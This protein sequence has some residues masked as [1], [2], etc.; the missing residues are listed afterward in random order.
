MKQPIGS[1]WESGTSFFKTFCAAPLAQFYEKHKSRINHILELLTALFMTMQAI[2]ILKSNH[3]ALGG[4]EVNHK[5]T[6][7]LLAL[8]TPPAPPAPP[9]PYM[10]RP[11]GRSLLAFFG[12]TERYDARLGRVRASC[13][14]I[15]RAIRPFRKSTVHSTE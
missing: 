5:L 12:R 13:M 11:G 1:G 3:K 14:P 2:I 10:R 6:F 8:P 4:Q 7:A 9:T 15:R